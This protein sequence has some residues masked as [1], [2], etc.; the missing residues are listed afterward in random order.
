[1]KERFP[2]LQIDGEMTAESALLPSVR[3]QFLDHSDLIDAANVLIMP[4]QESAHIALSLLRSFHKRLSIG[5]L[6]LGLDDVAYIANTTVTVRGLLNLASLAALDV[7]Q[8]QKV[9]ER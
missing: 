6:L 3:R 5:P 9:N 4:N 1:L 7:Q 8:K 2:D